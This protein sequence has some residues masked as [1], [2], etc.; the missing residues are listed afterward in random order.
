M[1][2]KL[3]RSN[4]DF[5]KFAEKVG[6]QYGNFQ[7]TEHL[8]GLLISP[9]QRLSKYN[10]L[11]SELA[12][13][14]EKEHPDYDNIIKA[15]DLM[16]QVSDVVNKS[17]FG[18]NK[19]MNIQ[20]M[21]SD[22][23]TGGLVSKTKPLVQP[24]RELVLE[25]DFVLKDR[26]S[27][28]TSIHVILCNDVIVFTKKKRLSSV[29]TFMFCEPIGNCMASMRGESKCE[30]LIQYGLSEN[31]NVIIEAS[32]EDERNAW[33]KEINGLCKKVNKQY[34]EKVMRVVSSTNT[35]D[36][37]TL[38]AEAVFNQE[39]HTENLTI[40]DSIVVEIVDEILEMSS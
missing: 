4:L 31:D 25:S 2:H 5:R 21:F 10:V 3:K 17:K 24:H 36:E 7:G 12:T 11:L 39:I 15:K 23:D 16:T 18:E 40:F 34:N 20:L 19:L 37:A 26:K 28:D 27:G 35:E 30:L 8:E 6:K 33:F 13:V 1:L 29:L 22:T 32:S 14:T 9:F 38:K